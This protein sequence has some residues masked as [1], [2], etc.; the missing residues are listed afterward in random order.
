MDIVNELTVSCLSYFSEKLGWTDGDD[1]TVNQKLD[2]IYSFLDL[3]QLNLDMN[4]AA[5]RILTEMAYQQIYRIK[6]KEYYN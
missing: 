5:K 4:P 2:A 6:E 1:V 3:I